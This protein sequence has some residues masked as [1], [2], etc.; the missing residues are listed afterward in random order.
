MNLIPSNIT[1]ITKSHKEYF[2][3]LEIGDVVIFHKDLIH[4][5]NYNS[6][7]KIRLVGVGRLTSNFNTEWEKKSYESY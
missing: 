3:F 4:K 1:E 7:D 6:S 5:S 2:N